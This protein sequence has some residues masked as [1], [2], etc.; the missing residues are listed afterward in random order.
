MAEAM[1]TIDLDKGVHDKYRVDY[2]VRRHID[3]Q[4]MCTVLWGRDGT[5]NYTGRGQNG[6]SCPTYSTTSHIERK[7]SVILVDVCVFFT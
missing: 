7:F 2:T 1:L 5:G 4:C 3:L 6:S